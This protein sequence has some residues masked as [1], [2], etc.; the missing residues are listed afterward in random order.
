MKGIMKKAAPLLLLLGLVTALSNCI[1]EDRAVELVLNDRT[2]PEFTTDEDTVSFALPPVEV[3]YASELD[4]ILRDNGVEREELV[5]ANLVSVLYG[6]TSF[7]QAHDWTIT[8]AITVE[9]FDI[10]DGPAT[11]VDYASYP[12]SSAAVGIETSLGLN[13]AGVGVMNRALSAFLAD[14]LPVLIFTVNN[15]GVSPKPS[16]TDRIIFDWKACLSMQIVTKA[17][18]EVPDPF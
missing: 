12:I 6:V 13:S 14:S 16:K 11:L 17:D 5:S 9:R 4:S 8:G 7:D 15:S 10:A 2:C 18:I 1:M 3:N